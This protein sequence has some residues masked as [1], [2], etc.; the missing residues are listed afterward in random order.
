MVLDAECLRDARIEN[1]ERLAAA[2]GVRLPP[3]RSDNRKY[4]RQL[5]RILLRALE[6]DR[7]RNPPMAVRR[8]PDA[9]AA[10]N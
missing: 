9:R 7:R 8:R 5:V 2:L 3:Q 1:L 10:L 6:E 4:A